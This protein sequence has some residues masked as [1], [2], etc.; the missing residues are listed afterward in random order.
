[1]KTE[2]QEE[3]VVEENPKANNAVEVDKNREAEELRRREEMR[4]RYIMYQQHQRMLHEQR[5]RQQNQNRSMLDSVNDFFV[6]MAA[7]LFG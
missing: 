6:G 1:M 2:E 5:I 3:A 7:S 4:R